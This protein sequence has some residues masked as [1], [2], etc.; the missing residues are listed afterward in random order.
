MTVSLDD[1][2]GQEIMLA[3]QAVD[4]PT[5]DGLWYVWFVDDISVGDVTFRNSDLVRVS[6]GEVTETRGVALQRNRAERE[7]NVGR[8]LLGYKVMRDDAVL[9]EELNALTY[10]DENV[11]NGT[12]V[13]SVMAQYTTGE[14][15]PVLTEEIT[16]LNADEDIVI[17]PVVTELKVTILTRS[18]PIPTYP[19]ACRKIA[20]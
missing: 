4:G 9:V 5:N 12:Y 15:D 20:R 19:S 13:Y 17:D 6:R 3:W 16:I 11:P 18:I 7:R 10:T 2:N 1:Y 8:E 14:S